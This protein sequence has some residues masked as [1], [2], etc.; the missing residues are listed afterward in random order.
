MVT[1]PVTKKFVFMF[2]G[3]WKSAIQTMVV[4]TRLVRAI[5]KVAVAGFFG[6]L[7][8]LGKMF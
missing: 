1:V 4:L 2:S 3:I 6:Y 5:F 8:A 7:S